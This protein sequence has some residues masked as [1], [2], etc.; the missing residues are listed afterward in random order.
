MTLALDIRYS[1]YC[2]RT[3]LQII[4]DNINIYRALDLPDLGPIFGPIPNAKKYHFFPN[5]DPKFSQFDSL[6]KKWKS[7][8][9]MIS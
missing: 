1:Q 5:L 9:K 7:G 8:E 6:K 3:E 4:L 2:F